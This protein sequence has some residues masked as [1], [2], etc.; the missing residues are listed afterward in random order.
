MHYLVQVSVRSALNQCGFYIVLVF[1]QWRSKDLRGPGSTNLGP[2]FPSLP[3]T[4]PSPF[5]PLSEPNPSSCREAA[6]QIQLGDLGSA[7]S[8]PAGLVQS[9]SRNLLVHFSRNIRHLVATILMIFLRVLPKIFLWSHYSGAPGALGPG[10][11][12]RLNTS[13]V[14]RRDASICIA[15]ISYGNMAGWLAVCLSQPVLYK[16]TTKP[17]LKLCRP[18]VSPITEAFGTSCADTKFQGKP[19]DRGHLIHGGGEN[20]RFLTELADISDTVRDRTM[21]T[22]E[23]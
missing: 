14:F 15:R 8:S 6:P 13:T 7:V 12:N 20:W 19:L 9:P 2:P 23:R 10:S 18:S 5:R 3:L 11:L 16:K 4:P 17:I 21:V 1:R 22:M